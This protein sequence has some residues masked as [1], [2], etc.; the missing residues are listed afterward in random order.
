MSHAGEREP[1]VSLGPVDATMVGIGA[2]IFVP[3]RRGRLRPARSLTVVDY[4]GNRLGGPDTVLE[5]GHRY[6]VAV[7]SGATDE[8][9]NL[10]RG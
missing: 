1:T 9:M 10:L 7:E 8:V 2:G 6:V 3:V 5:P 4:Q